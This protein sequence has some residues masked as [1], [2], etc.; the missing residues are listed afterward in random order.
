IRWQSF[1]LLDAHWVHGVSAM[2][3][4]AHNIFIHLLAET[5][6][7]GAL[8]LLAGVWAWLRGFQ[9]RNITP[10]GWWLLALLAII[11]IHSLLEYPLWYAYFLG[12]VALLLGVG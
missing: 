12:P 3:E 4:H 1:L 7:A 5:G 6:I 9:W 10:E 2:H 11:G 8:L